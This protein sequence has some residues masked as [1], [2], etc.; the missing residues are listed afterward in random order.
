MLRVAEEMASLVRWS[1]RIRHRFSVPCQSGLSALYMDHNGLRNL[2]LMTYELYE[3][4]ESAALGADASVDGVFQDRY[5]SFAVQGL[6]A[7]LI[8]RFNRHR[9]VVPALASASVFNWPAVYPL[10]LPSVF[11]GA[12]R[13]SSTWFTPFADSGAL[14]GSFPLRAPASR[15]E[16]DRSIDA[17]S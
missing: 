11:R 10:N 17:S 3:L 5:K 16:R 1:V 12:E 13:A 4:V 8:S 7:L 2:R 6:P 9:R 15:S 14:V